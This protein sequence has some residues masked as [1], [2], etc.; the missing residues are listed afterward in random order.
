MPRRKQIKSRIPQS[1]RRSRRTA[2]PGGPSLEGLAGLAVG[3]STGYLGAEGA[4]ASNPH[5]LHW[6]AAALIAVIGYWA[7]EVWR[8]WR[9]S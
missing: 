7:G 6:I 3:A 8:R 5:P 4:M 9:R 2:D 1:R